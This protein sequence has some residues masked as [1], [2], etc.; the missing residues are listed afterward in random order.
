MNTRAAWAAA[1]AAGAVV[2]I[3]APELQWPARL[4]AALL[5]GP[6]PI[7]IMM[8]A[9]GLDHIPRPITRLPIYFGSMIA[10]AVL[11]AAAYATGRMSGFSASDF[12]FVTIPVAQMAAWTIGM[13][14]ITG[15]IVWGFKAAGVRESTIMREIT[16]VTTS[17]KIAFCGLSVSAGVCEEVAFRGFLLTALTIATGSAA[18]GVILSSLAFGILHAHQNAGG[19]ARA[20]LLGAALCG[21]VLVTGSIYPSMAAH[22]LID[23]AG[24]LWLA[25]WLFR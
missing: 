9:G 16:P 24:G 21:P 8:Q 4:M 22:T 15:I 6:A 23:V 25:N 10:L 3:A 17:E 7:A 12:G 11:G 18:A 5:L 13:I 19:A 1:I 2:W 20:A 14:L